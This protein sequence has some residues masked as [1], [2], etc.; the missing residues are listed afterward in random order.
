[1]VSFR[2]LC[3]TFLSTEKTPLSVQ[4]TLPLQLNMVPRMYMLSTWL[5]PTLLMVAVLSMMT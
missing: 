2:L 3:F 1:M 5:V 4:L